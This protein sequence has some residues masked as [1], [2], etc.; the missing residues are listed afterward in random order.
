MNSVTTQQAG[1]ATDS[2]D[3]LPQHLVKIPGESWALWR[4]IFLRGAGFPF[5]LPQQLSA[6]GETIAAA[7]AVLEAESAASLAQ[8]NA[9]A[10]VNAALDA[11]REQ[12][13]WNDKSRR[14]PLL[15]ARDRI[16][17]GEAPK[18]L[19]E[20]DGLQIIEHFRET[21]E[22]FRESRSIFQQKFATGSALTSNTIRE[23]AASPRFREAVM[24]QNR[25]AIHTALD[26]L[27]KKS[28]NNQRNSD[29]RQKEEMVANYLQRYC[30]KNDTVGFFGPVGWAKLVDSEASLSASPGSNLVAKSS[31][32]FENWCIEALAEKI[33]A[34]KPLRPWLA[35]RLLPFFRVEAGVLCSSAP[36][37]QLSAVH[38][39]IL[40]RCTGE[41]TA[42]EIAQAVIA[43]PAYGV[44]T[45]GQVYG[46]LQGYAARGIISWALEIPYCL[47][48]QQKLR[49]LL[50]KIEK[51]E[52]RRPLLDELQ[53]LEDG[54]KKI[55][56]ALGDP[57][58]L[59]KALAEL[60]TT[61]TRLTSRSATKAAGS[62]Y[63]SRTLVYHDCQRDAQVE[64]GPE[65]LATLGAPLAFL[66]NSARWFSYQAAA[67][68]REKF[69]EIFEELAQKSQS[70]K[71]DMLQFSARVEP[72]IFDPVKRLFNDI[73][74]EFQS[75]WEA[76]LQVPWEKQKVEYTSAMLKPLVESSFAIPTAGWQLARYHS[77]DV[78]IAASGPD[79]IRR[80]DYMFVLGEVHMGE[81][82]LRFSFD[83]SQHDKPEELFEAFQTDLPQ[84]RVVPVPPRHWPRI[85][86][87][88][89]RA[90]L[91]PHDHY[92][93]ISS[94]PVADAPRSRV[95]PIGDLAVE[96]SPEGLIVRSWD[97]SLQFDIIE[98]F[99]EFFSGAT[100]ELM[101][102]V[103]RHPHVP[104][105]TIDKLVVVRE[106]WSF[107]V[108]ELDFIRLEAEYERF[109]EVRRWM[110]HHRLP[111]FVF[112]HVRI[113]VKPF[114]LDFESPI[115]VEVFIKTVRRMAVSDCKEGTITLTEMLPATDEVWLPD[116]QGRR[117]TSELRIVAWDLAE[118]NS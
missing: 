9:L 73:V 16:R 57:E 30:L 88:T 32:F 108:N 102:I 106:S 72:L 27:L 39:A 53:Q 104:R 96:E 3:A 55:E 115:Y 34:M 37:S 23:F 58:Q 111:R 63:A 69:R 54:R 12:N 71:V 99:G 47:H 79:A 31:V 114:Y 118:Q 110:H 105:I 21:L 6:P 28:S 52:L 56:E 107:P 83:L 89:S 116:N 80:G 36:V 101:K 68:F 8:Q 10:Q 51:E 24:W 94:S 59:E 85:T 2:A 65:L 25:T 45:E 113:E 64:I 117:Y 92:L 87:R 98:F 78:M 84:S 81:N 1:L 82:T 22:K 86:N 35:P 61:F 60:D 26:P 33:S 18:R 11:L 46:I 95:I 48:P 109:L 15:K 77:P 97:G 75:R 4:W 20:F 38:T 100:I 103:G 5:D 42:R 49:Q 91:S 112:V 43:L 40:E 50:Q 66:L 62:M 7:H 19:P 74:P 93:E 13:Q 67:A 44:R 29:L 14:L 90:L 17:S 76:I 70:R 41:F